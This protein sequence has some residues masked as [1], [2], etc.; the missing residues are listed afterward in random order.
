MTIKGDRLKQAREI[1]GLT[2]VQLA[3]KLDVSQ[4]CIAQLERD[5][6]V[7]FEP[8]EGLV[9]ALSLSLGFMPSFFS[10]LGVPEFP[11]GSLLYRKRN[12]LK[13]IDENRIRQFA[14]LVFEIS[15]RLSKN[16]RLPSVN[17]PRILEESPAEAAQ[18]TRAALGLSPDTPIKN[19]IYQL[20]KKGVL[21]IVVPYEIDEHDAFSLWTSSKSKPLMVISGGKSGDRQRFNVAHELGHLVMHR[22]YDGNVKQREDEAN[23]FA[24]EFLMPGEVLRNEI[25]TPVTIEK[26]AVLKGR[27]GVS[28]QALAKKSYDLEIINYRQYTYLNKQINAFGWRKQE[29]NY[30]IAEKPRAF[31]KMIE[32]TYGSSIDYEKFASDF[33]LSVSLAKMITEGYADL[34]DLA[35]LREREKSIKENSFVDEK[36]EAIHKI[37]MFSKKRHSVS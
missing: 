37:I 19:L 29:P 17:L 23:D 28:I 24:S 4:S 21:V 22:S 34:K 15:E 14:K 2:Q 20:E 6:R 9:Q 26:L 32:V 12:S 3:E 8:S 13:A 18:L 5:E 27:W 11:L 7:G 31:R 33:N 25:E 16:L 1:R 36:V 35:Q 10:S 30:I